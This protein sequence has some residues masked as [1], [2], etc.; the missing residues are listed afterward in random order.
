MI[1]ATFLGVVIA[2]AALA[3]LLGAGNAPAKGNNDVIKS[4]SCSG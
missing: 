4:G 1:K 3:A 2:V